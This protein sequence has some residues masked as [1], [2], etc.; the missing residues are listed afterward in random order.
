M[1]RRP[2]AGLTLVELMV[3]TLLALATMAAFTA[4]LTTIL[5]ARLRAAEVAEAGMA[6]AGAI[7][8]IVRDV[9]LAGYD[10]AARGIVGI[11]AASATGVVLG[12]D[13]DG[14][15]DVNPTSEEQITYRTANGG[16]TLQRIVGQQSLPLLSDLA[17][18]GFRLGY[19]DADGVELDPQAP[20][21]S[22]AARAVTV[23]LA[24]RATD[25]HAALRM[26]GA[27]RL[28]NR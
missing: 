26:R 25:T 18:G 11:S 27:G 10:P 15:G 2:P 19:L 21:A 12:A 13:L 9:R 23:E 17:P 22:A 4:L 5:V 7:D 6:A 14:S 8:Q 20:G 28:L 3:A 24:L 16:D 1:P